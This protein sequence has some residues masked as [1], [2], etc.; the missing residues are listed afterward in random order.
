MSKT[1]VADIVIPTEFE[2][3]AIER[4]A[5][6]SKFGQS[7]IIEMDPRFDQLAAMGGKLVPMPFWKDLS[8]ARQILSDSASLTLNKIQGDQDQ[9]CI[10]NDGNA[11]SVNHLAEVI[12]GDD[13]LQAIV[14]LVAEYWARTDEGILVSC[15]KGIFAAASMAGNKLSIASESVAGQSASTKLNGSTFVDATHKLGDRA[16]GVTAVAMHSATEG[17]LMKL[18]LI[19][20]VPDST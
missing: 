17:A 5:E 9:A 3:Y 6:L 15:L 16:E 1:V 20:F 10:H 12:S 4:T 18:D 8:G 19:D 7:G 11:W 13:P 2:K 14:D